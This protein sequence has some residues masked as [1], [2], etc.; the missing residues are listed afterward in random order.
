MKQ[1][2]QRDGKNCL[3]KYTKHVRHDKSIHLM[4]WYSFIFYNDNLLDSYICLNGWFFTTK[5]VIFIV[6]YNYKILMVD[7]LGRSDSEWHMC[8]RHASSSTSDI[9]IY[10][11][12]VRFRNQ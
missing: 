10:E 9:Y 7:V 8:P 4:R 1:Q 3:R 11:D 5:M 2:P 12:D 6:R